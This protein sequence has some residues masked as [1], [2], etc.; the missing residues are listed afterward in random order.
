M[1]PPSATPFPPSSSSARKSS[2]TSL[3]SS[4]WV[5]TQDFYTGYRKTVLAR[6]EILTRIRIPLPQYG[7]VFKL[8][9]VSRRKDLDISTFGAAIFMR[10]AAQ[11]ID[12]IRVALGGVAP[13]V[14][15]LPPLSEA[16]LTGKP[17]SENLFDQAGDIANGEITPISDVRLR[18][19]P[20]NSRREYSPKILA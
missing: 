19:L 9:K 4:R 15:R 11:S 7:E 12:E 3:E 13:V 16:F 1:P 5:E 18:G 17:L 8:Y 6:G 2:S 20:S 10:T 14:V